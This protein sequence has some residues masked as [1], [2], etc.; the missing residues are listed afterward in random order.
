MAINTKKKSIW[1]G[2]LLLPFLLYFYLSSGVQLCFGA[3]EFSYRW[4][5]ERGKILG[6]LEAAKIQLG[7]PLACENFP[8]NYLELNC[9]K[10]ETYELINDIELCKQKLTTDYFWVSGKGENCA[11]FATIPF[12]K[13]VIQLKIRD[14]DKKYCGHKYAE[15]AGVCYQEVGKLDFHP[16]NAITKNDLIQEIMNLNDDAVLPKSIWEKYSKNSQLIAISLLARKRLNEKIQDDKIS[17][18]DFDEDSELQMAFPS[19][20]FDKIVANGFLNQHQ[21]IHSGGR[22]DRRGRTKREDEMMG[23]KLQ[24]PYLPDPSDPANMVRPKYGFF[25]L[26]KVEADRNPMGEMAHTE[27]GDVFAVFGNHIKDRTTF[28]FHDSINVSPNEVKTLAA[29]IN[30]PPT[31]SAN[32]MEAQIWGELTLADVK[33]FI[34]NC[35]QPTPAEIIS[36][37]KGTGLEVYDCETERHPY[38]ATSCS[39]LPLAQVSKMV[40]GL[41]TLSVKEKKWPD[42]QNHCPKSNLKVQELEI[43]YSAVYKV[44]RGKKL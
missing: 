43:E 7:D 12:G 20:L 13:T 32:Y 18:F 28:S 19:S 35:F 10:L 8:N 2:G 34:V 26:P 39:L 4:I 37:M 6:C 23:L 44:K 29:K 21:T 1:Q 24:E 9:L 40:D 36:R 17:R 33:Y 14:F 27:Y 22:L 11:E 31:Q 38:F 3:M 15:G 5:G 16:L 41:F 30:N 42:G 25:T